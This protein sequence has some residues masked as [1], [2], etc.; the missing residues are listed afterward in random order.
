MCLDIQP[1]GCYD[2]P[3]DLNGEIVCY[4]VMLEYDSIL[5]SPYKKTIYPKSGIYKS[6]RPSLALTE[7]EKSNDYVKHG[8]HVLLE[9][10]DCNREI[11]FWRGIYANTDISVVVIEVRCNQEHLVATGWF[12][13]INSAVFTQVEVIGEVSHVY[14]D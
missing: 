8:V 14:V 5:M 12:N 11:A 10:S 2:L 6:D 13:F 1:R 4:K 3:F 7:E 9:V